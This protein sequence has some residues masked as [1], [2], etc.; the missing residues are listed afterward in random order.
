[1]Q[2]L[3]FLF[4]YYFEVKNTTPS[5]LLAYKLDTH[6]LSRLID[7]SPSSKL[8]IKEGGESRGWGKGE[9]KVLEGSGCCITTRWAVFARCF[10]KN[11]TTEHLPQ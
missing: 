8:E 11:G 7:L 4:V 2:E 5:L 6:L 3:F 9:G 1:M 10:A